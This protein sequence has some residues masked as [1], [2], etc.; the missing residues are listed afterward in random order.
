M[1]YFS[2]TFSSVS[3]GSPAS[4]P[5]ELSPTSTRWLVD[6]LGSGTRDSADPAG[7]FAEEG[8][9]PLRSRQTSLTP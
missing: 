8:V 1:K 9:L 2:G 4:S 5:V 3:R 6:R 7:G